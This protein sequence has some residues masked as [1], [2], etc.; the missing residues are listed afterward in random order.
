M[1]EVMALL[2]IH[3]PDLLELFD[4]DVALISIITGMSEDHINAMQPKE[5]GKW[6]TELYEL[7]AKDIEGD[8]NTVLRVGGHK[9]IFVPSASDVNMRTLT[10]YQIIQNQIKDYYSI[11]PYTVALFAEESRGFNIFRKKL[12]FSEKVEL[13][14]EL[15]VEAAN[16]IG[17]FFCEVYPILE[18]NTQSYLE[19]SVKEAQ[20]SLTQA[21]EEMRSKDG[22][23]QK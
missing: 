2:N 13:F 23:L 4:R 10:D 8:F 3:T 5:F 15:P 7:I 21:L 9:F 18:R 6:R 11:L 20:I 22:A 12:T 19:R 17:L 1:P 14:K 16:G